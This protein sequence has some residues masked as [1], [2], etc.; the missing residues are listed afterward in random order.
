MDLPRFITS[1]V[2]LLRCCAKVSPT[3]EKIVKDYF[4][5]VVDLSDV[6]PQDWPNSPWELFEV[7]WE[8]IEAGEQ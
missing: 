3:G 5:R 4:G 7:A 8:G 1:F 2:W 6:D